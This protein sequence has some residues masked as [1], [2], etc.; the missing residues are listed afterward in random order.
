MHWDQPGWGIV[1]SPLSWAALSLPVHHRA[2]QVG[3]C[4]PLPVPV[5]YHPLILWSL[6]H[7]F[8]T[9]L[10]AL[11]LPPQRP[12]QELE[13]TG[14]SSLSCLAVETWPLC[15]PVLLKVSLAFLS[16][17]H[18]PQWLGRKNLRVVWEGEEFRL[19]SLKTERFPEKE[20]LWGVAMDTR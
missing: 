10:L 2:C 7:S 18:G 19:F 4:C 14:F 3:F 11:P 9:H 20:Q 6:T 8:L 16:R 15:A 12:L 5:F 1:P 17:G 13:G